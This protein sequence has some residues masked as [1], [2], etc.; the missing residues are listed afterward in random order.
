M[1]RS[2]PR[3]N[4]AP[5]TAAPVNATQECCCAA[6]TALPHVTATPVT[7][8]PVTAAPV[9]AAPQECYV[10]LGACLKE[11]PDLNNIASG[12]ALA[13]A[14]A[15]SGARVTDDP[16]V[17]A[18]GRWRIRVVCVCVCVCVCV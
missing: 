11:L 3:R 17:R 12:L 18:R 6:L 7:A 4:V 1:R 15:R 10:A 16:Q 5:F 13:P 2:K 8:P 9:I 14:M